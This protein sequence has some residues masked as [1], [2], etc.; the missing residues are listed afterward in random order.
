MAKDEAGITWAMFTKLGNTRF[1]KIVLTVD[2]K[3]LVVITNSA[4]R[5]RVQVDGLR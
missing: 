4:R 5:F 2:E 1:I 3:E